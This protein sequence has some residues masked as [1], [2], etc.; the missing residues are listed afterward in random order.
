MNLN[1]IKN[2][3]SFE[4]VYDFVQKYYRWFFVLAL[5]VII[6]SNALIFYKKVYQTIQAKPEVNLRERLIDQE[7]LSQILT[8]LEQRKENMEQ[9][10]GKNYRN[11]FLP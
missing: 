11:I 3:I 6:F 10:E 4:G 9:V 2:S 7:T 1:S 8:E 5:L